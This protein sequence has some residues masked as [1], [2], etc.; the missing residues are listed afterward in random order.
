M[1]RY[2]S[3]M[4]ICG[5]VSEGDTFREEVDVATAED[6]RAV[7]QEFAARAPEQLRERAALVFD[8][9]VNNALEHGG[10]PV[11]VDII[12][13]VRGIAVGTTQRGPFLSETD[14]EALFATNGDP[15]L[16]QANGRG[17]GLVLLRA[18]ADGCYANAH[19]RQLYAVLLDNGK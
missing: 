11:R 17:G 16:F 12:Y 9:V 4:E 15:A 7:R 18:Y 6:V 3:P 10:A 13:G 19:N 1:E 8:E 14:V 5:V 2:R